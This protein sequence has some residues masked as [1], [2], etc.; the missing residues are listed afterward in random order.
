MFP[1]LP[2]CKARGVAELKRFGT[3]GGLM[4]D[5]DNSVGTNPDVPVGFTVL[6]QFVTH[7]FSFDPSPMPFSNILPAG[8]S[9]RNS[10]RFDLDNVYGGGPM[11]DTALYPLPDRLHFALGEGGHD[12]PRMPDTTVIS[13]DPRD[14]NNMPLAQL[15]L[16]FMKF[17]N[18]IIDALIDKKITTATGH[19][20]YQEPADE[21]PNARDRTS[22]GALLDKDNWY[23]V[24][25][26]QAQRLV[27]WHYQW[28]ILN[29]YLPLICDRS[30]LAEVVD[31]GSTLFPKTSDR[32]FVPIEFSTGAFRYAHAVLHAEYRIND[33]TVLPMFKDTPEGGP[34]V[35][36]RGGAV[37]AEHALD[38]S[39]F[40]HTRPDREPKFERLITPKFP[41]PLLNLPVRGVPGARAG[42]L[43]PE[44]SS[45]AVRDLCR[46]EMQGLPSGQDIARAVGQEPLTDAELGTEGP[47][48]FLWYLLKEAELLAGGR[49][50]GPVASRIVAESFVGLLDSDPW[51]YRRLRPNW[52]PTLK[53]LGERFGMADFVTIGQGRTPEQA[54]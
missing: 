48:Y 30:I 49:H 19:H 14:D 45:L 40:F 53:P 47:I 3:P 1:D 22:L 44:M 52:Q 39:Y 29:E 24:L 36:L 20:I 21:T 11:G 15:H 16:A 35:D 37:A 54:E 38:W 18:A 32:P 42:A 43:S 4:D 33:N 27:C 25:F 8:I 23:N 28:M 2:A 12:L 17:H 31:N 51:S 46:G 26:A 9:N 50:L 10:P 7:D 5:T 34:R 6:G 41:T 13:P